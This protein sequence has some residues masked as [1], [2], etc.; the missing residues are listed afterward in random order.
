M[1]NG[2]KFGEERWSVVRGIFG[3]VVLGFCVSFSVIRGKCG[4]VSCVE[5]RG[6]LQEA[7]V[8]FGGQF[9][10]TSEEFWSLFA[11]KGRGQ[12]NWFSVSGAGRIIGSLSLGITHRSRPRLR[13]ASGL[14]FL[15]LLLLPLWLY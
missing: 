5:S 2:A 4:V 9:R 8:R 1:S 15:P 13:D 7:W 10:M 12:K 11:V 14:F 6:V 3:K